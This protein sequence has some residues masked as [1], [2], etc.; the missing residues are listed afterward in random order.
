[1]ELLQWIYYCPLTTTVSSLWNGSL[2]AL[3][4]GFLP[5]IKTTAELLVADMKQ[6]RERSRETEHN[7]TFVASYY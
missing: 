3:V 6:D 1:M 7:D 2:P 5:D 4:S